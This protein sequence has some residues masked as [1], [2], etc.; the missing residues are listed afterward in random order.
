MAAREPTNGGRNSTNGADAGRGEEHDRQPITHGP[1]LSWQDALAVNSLPIDSLL[2]R[3]TQAATDQR[4]VVIQ[5]APGAGKTTRVPPALLRAGVAG[6]DGCIVMLEP[7]RIAAR[8]A[9]RRIAEEGGWQLGREVGYRIRLENRSSAD[10]RIL[11]VTEGV[12]VAMLQSDP[13]LEGISTIVFDEFHE[14]R[15]DSDLALAMARRVQCE[16]REDLALIVMSATLDAAPVAAFLGNCPVI[17]SAGRQHP[18]DIDYLAPRTAQSLAEQ[19]AAGVTHALAHTDGD[20]L[21]FLPGVGEIRQAEDRLSALAAKHDLAVLPLFGALST[22][23]QDAALRRGP[24][25]RV[26]LATNVAETSVT[27]DGVSAVVDSGLARVLRYDPASGLDRLEVRRIARANADQRAGRAGRLGPGRAI[28]L[29]G[30]HEDRGLRQHET[31]EI[32]R[33]DLAGP[34][35]QLLAWGE[36]DPRQFAWFEPPEDA[37]LTRAM[38]LL[39]LL[40][41][42]NKTGVTRR[43]RQMASLGLHPRLARLLVAGHELGCLALAA[44]MAALLTER[45]VVALPE[46]GRGQE[47]IRAAGSSESDVLDR[48]DALRSFAD[49]GR[50]ETLVGPLHR[51]RARRALTEADHLEKRARRVLGAEPSVA[52]FDHETGRESLYEGGRR[53]L[54]SAFPDRVAR[55]RTR[56][57]PRG[58]MVGGRGVRLLPMSSVREDELFVC[59]ELAAGQGSNASEAWVRQASAIERPWLDDVGPGLQ[60]TEDVVFDPESERVAG[61]RRL[62]YGDLVLDEVSCPPDPT[63]AERVLCAAAAAD[64]HRALALDRPDIAR[65]LTRARCL[66]HWLP[67]AD[68]PALDDGTL[69]DLLPSIA[70]GARS[71]R[72]L[73]KA[74]VLDI[75]RGHLGHPIIQTVDREAPEHLRLPSGKMAKLRYAEGEP[76]VLAVRIQQ[77]FGWQETPTIANGRI[78]VL[79]HLLA[80]NMRPQQI[81][82]DL[83]SFWRNTYP[84]VRKELAGRYPKHAWPL[85]PLAEG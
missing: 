78:E 12:L 14:R 27:V 69:R 85:D 70:A 38:T 76:P 5:A 62:R 63:E 51:G 30:E 3:I 46:R 6:M 15:L 43:G 67:D 75:L 36:A 18:V 84:Q 72:A 55:R 77:I 31:A 64:L 66:H 24:R 73:R 1:F 56:H 4:A 61:L 9:A 68:L 40:G 54:L 35:L 16:V 53:A 2:E 80:P 49:R 83:A 45:D 82:R 10:T 47:P 32:K 50:G 52:A 7:R 71:F 34:I 26:V 57:Q 39:D 8:A 79:L 33:T 23:E 25:R 44:R 22:A 74:P 29:W 42:R 41:A 81:T 17:E 58:V 21:V 13:L 19:V 28:R 59:I 65:F 60:S 48:L 37:A 11:V 20:V